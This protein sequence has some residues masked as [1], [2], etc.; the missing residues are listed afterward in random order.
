MIWAKL[1]Y[2]YF[3]FSLLFNIINGQTRNEKF[4]LIEQSIKFIIS[5]RE[6]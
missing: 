1:V 2:I 5:S 3:I 6:V 4:K